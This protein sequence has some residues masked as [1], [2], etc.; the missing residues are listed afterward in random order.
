MRKVDPQFWSSFKPAIVK[1]LLEKQIEVQ[2]IMSA[3]NFSLVPI[4][5]D[6]AAVYYGKLDYIH[7]APALIRLLDL[8]EQ[9]YETE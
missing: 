3:F 4:Q 5:C 9:H 8:Y 6:W 7:Y 2:S 1:G